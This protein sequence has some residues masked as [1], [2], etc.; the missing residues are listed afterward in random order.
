M[1]FN[2]PASLIVHCMCNG[3]RVEVL[4]AGHMFVNNVG[5]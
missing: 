1:F 5:Y 3:P 2:Q 4:L